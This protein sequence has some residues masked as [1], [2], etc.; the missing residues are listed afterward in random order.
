MELRNS[1]GEIVHGSSWVV[2]SP[3][4][5]PPAIAATCKS[6]GSPLI[7]FVA[8]LDEDMRMPQKGEPLTAEQI[9]LLRAW[10]DQGAT[11]PDDGKGAAATETHWSFKPVVRPEVPRV[12]GATNAVASQIPR[13]I[14]PG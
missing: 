9:G 2:G 14:L 6:G 8:G 4:R 10:I 12:E 7:H 5:A 13:V 11:W 3:G 1:S